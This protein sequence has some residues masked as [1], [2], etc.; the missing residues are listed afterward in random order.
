MPESREN[1][2]HNKASKEKCKFATFNFR[3]KSQNKKFARIKTREI[4]I[5]TVPYMKAGKLLIVMDSTVCNCAKFVQNVPRG[6]P[7]NK[8]AT[9]TLLPL[10]PSIFGFSFFISTLCTTF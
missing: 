6:R 4:T 9:R 7:T 10:V 3:E 5:Y 1:Y 2:Y 8:G